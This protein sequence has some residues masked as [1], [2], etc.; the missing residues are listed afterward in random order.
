[1]ATNHLLATP[2]FALPLGSSSDDEG[3]SNN[4]AGLFSFGQNTY[5][6]LALGDTNDRSTP[7]RVD[8]G[9]IN[10][11]KHVVDV[12]CGNEQTT[13]LFENGDVFTCGYNDSGQCAIGTT[14]R[15]PSLRF[16]PGLSSHHTV[17]LFS[18]NGSEHLA[19]LCANGFLYTV[20]FN[21]R[22]QL[23]LGTATTVTE[24]TLVEELAGKRVVDVACS[25][26]HTAIVMDNGDLHAC[27]CNDYGQ[28]GMGD[29]SGHLVPRPVDYFFRHPVLAVACGQ[30]YTVASLRDGGVVAFG[31]NDHG[32]L[33]LDRVSEPVLLP[34]RLAPPLDRAVVP[35]LSCGYHHTAIVTEDGA[36]YTFGRNDYG[37]LGLGHK[38]HMARPTPVESL[39]RMR[40]TQ[41]ACGCYHTLALSDDGK[42]FPFGRNN[43]G[44]L[45]LETSMDCLSP[46]LISTLR[47]K[48]VAAGF[49]HSV[50]LVGT[51]KSE[52]PPPYTLS[53]D[54]RK[55]LN[56]PTRS[57]TTFV[58]EGR[59][60]FA[61]SCILV[62]RCEPLEK[63]LDGRMKDGAQPEIVIPEY[64]YDVFAALMEFLYTDQVAV[65]A[66]PDLTADFALELHALADQYLVTTLR[67]ACENSLLQILSVENVVIIVES[68]HF[69]NAFTL[70]KR[71]LGFI[72]DHFARVIATQAFVGLPQELLQEILLSASHQGVSI[73]NQANAGATTSEYLQSR[74]NYSTE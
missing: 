35:Q 1:M 25:Y 21:M 50:C 26:F 47:N 65:L 73:P 28:L 41:V 46:Q 49:Y 72:M 57:D 6:E 44:Q 10:D 34:T 23:G 60:L 16:S 27:G 29:H 33:G 13:I 19:A 70:K 51:P 8:L 63:M 31:K 74:Y 71:C 24:A 52:N 17:R 7:T 30:H 37:Q 45:G 48:P 42:V 32:Q 18:G 56:N 4:R 62:A 9:R 2:A 59:P 14:E 38:L 20:G 53:G 55:M 39:S 22:G 36:V 5:G 69:R 43:H 64:S 68:A 3:S 61:H 12:A 11:T 54:L 15:V 58:I 67:S 66:S 40:I